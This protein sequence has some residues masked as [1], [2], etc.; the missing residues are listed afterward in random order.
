MKEKKFLVSLNA[1]DK[2]K[3]FVNIITGFIADFDLVSGRY[4]IDGKSIMGVFS[5]DLTKHI[6]LIVH[7]EDDADIVK[8]EAAIADFIVKEN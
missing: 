7:Y 5:L 1:I 3:K 8:I 2:V 4:V 6:E